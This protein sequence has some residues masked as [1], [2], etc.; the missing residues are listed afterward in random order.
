MDRRASVTI[1]SIAEAIARGVDV[2][3]DAQP[4]TENGWDLVAYR[5][6]DLTGI[7]YF[8]Y[9]RPSGERAEVERAQPAGPQHAGWV[10]HN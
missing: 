7:G 6:D 5:W 9:E 2:T 1:E 8:S 10:A 3:S 4:S